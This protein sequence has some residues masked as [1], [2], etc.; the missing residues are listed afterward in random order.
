MKVSL[1]NSSLSNKFFNFFGELKEGNFNRLLFLQQTKAI[2]A[3][4]NVKN[5]ST[6]VQVDSQSC[7]VGVQMQDLASGNDRFRKDD[8]DAREADEDLRETNETRK[9][10]REVMEAKGKKSEK[11]VV[12]ENK[13]KMDKRKN[14]KTKEETVK[15][16]NKPVQKRKEVNEDKEKENETIDMKAKSKR[17]AS[18]KRKTSQP[19]FVTSQNETEKLADKEQTTTKHEEQ[20]Q[21]PTQAE[22]QAVFHERAN[23]SK[24]WLVPSAAQGDDI[25]FQYSTTPGRLQKSEEGRKSLERPGDQT[26]VSAQDD[27]SGS[28]EVT[29]H[30]KKGSKVALKDL[31]Q[32]AV[33]IE[34]ILN[35]EAMENEGEGKVTEEVLQDHQGRDVVIPVENENVSP[36]EQK[37][38]LIE[39]GKDL[40]GLNEAQIQLQDKEELPVADTEKTNACRDFQGEELTDVQDV[41]EKMG[42]RCKGKKESK[43]EQKTRQIKPTEEKSPQNVPAA[44][45][46]NKSQ[47]RRVLRSRTKEGNSGVEIDTNKGEERKS[48]GKE[49]RQK[50]QDSDVQT[51]ATKKCKTDVENSEGRE[52]GMLDK[53]SHEADQFPRETDMSSHEIDRLVDEPRP[54]RGVTSRKTAGDET[55]QQQEPEVLGGLNEGNT[56]TQSERLKDY[57]SDQ[58]S[59]VLND[60]RIRKEDDAIFHGCL[61]KAL[62]EGKSPCQN[63]PYPKENN[64]NKIDLSSKNENITREG[65]QFQNT[66][67]VSASKK[68]DSDT[69][70]A[71]YNKHLSRQTAKSTSLGT[72]RS[73][74]GG[75]DLAKVSGPKATSSKENAPRLDGI[76]KGRKKRYAINHFFSWLQAFLKEIINPCFSVSFPS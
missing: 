47:G 55:S 24:S 30:S 5:A 26:C 57:K 37:S 31:P 28:I 17:K 41:N 19:E 60:N 51:V 13:P 75:Q 54:S 50:P 68:Q 61:H 18:R 27:V 3:M 2:Q 66:N 44:D 8:D 36:D 4:V 67:D 59:L 6:M 16:K 49:T 46:T 62:E 39:E 38:V 48:L 65:E 71:D 63:G 76:V 11:G 58:G 12:K 33:C 1:L 7:D 64:N 21:S 72:G 42:K 69:I 73:K 35:K 74:R 9:G 20:Q 25:P 22:K 29:S 53:S 56:C 15:E 43:R 14:A 34:D 45:K 10:K 70:E 40:L 32:L 23:A 52:P